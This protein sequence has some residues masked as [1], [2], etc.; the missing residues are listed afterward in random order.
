MQAVDSRPAV[1]TLEHDLAIVLAPLTRPELGEIRI[2]GGAFAVGRSEPLFAAYDEDILVMLSRRHAR[3]FCEQGSVYLADLDSRNGTTLNRERIG[4]APCRLRHGD[5]VGFGGVL[6]FRVEIAPR[7]G[8]PGRGAEVTTLTLTPAA[9]DS[10]LGPIVVARF[11]FLVGKS[12]AAFAPCREQQPAQLSYLSRRHAHLFSRDGRV[13]IEDLGSTNGTFVDGLRLQ[14][15]AVPLDDGMLLAFGGDHFTY[16]VSLGQQAASVAAA[17]TALVVSDKTTFVAAPTSF[18]EIFCGDTE[19]P[20]DADVQAAVAP[21]AALQPDAR[22]RP[23][24]RILLLWSE[25]ASLGVGLDDGGNK[26]RAWRAAALALALLAGGVALYLHSAPERALK[27]ALARGDHAQAAALADRALEGR[28][29][30]VELKAQATQAALE[31]NVPA[32]LAAVQ[33]RNFDAARAVLAA[34]APL[35]TR[36]PELRPMLGELEWLGDLERL[37]AERGGADAPIRIYADEER[38]AALVERWNENTG[39]RQRTLARIASH[40]PPF[41]AAF[42]DA[43]TH[44]RRLQS[45]AMVYLPAIERLKTAIAAELERDSALSISAMLD[46]FAAKYPGV[47][48]LDV[49]RQDLAHFLELGSGARAPRSGRLF[50]ALAQARFATPPFQAAFRTLAAQRQ[51]PPPPLVEQYAQATQAWQEGRS[52]QALAALRALATGPWAQTITDELQRRQAVL[53]QYTALQASRESIGYGEQLL[54]FRAALDADEDIF[55]AR[56]TQADL[57]LHKDKAL[58]RASDAMNR[59]RTLWQEYLSGGAIEARQRAESAISA[60]FRARAA[61]LAQARALARQATQITTQLG[62]TLPASSRAIADEIDSEAVQQ[63][64][65]LQELRNV[66][67]PA[68]LKDKLALL[69][70][71]KP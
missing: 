61:L 28:P 43:L 58:A 52:N 16:R 23:R 7:A 34:M 47:G 54:A 71:P 1:P 4:S 39:E 32:W 56:A 69:G 68:L 18:L 42:A 13:W 29:D 35:V 53:A 41:A 70:E 12:D 65:A 49:L 19:A 31:A 20:P 57:A 8:V 48:G 59:A 64:N 37:V 40:V 60:P 30:D 62:A 50:A 55:F 10:A 14:E 45:D 25:L 67:E 11:P 21:V 46:A 17:T 66:L 63:R 44:L 51:L 2:E 9:E 5:E 6:S 15:H 27:D 33:A 36:N 26:R 38:I 24:G 3:L 22:R